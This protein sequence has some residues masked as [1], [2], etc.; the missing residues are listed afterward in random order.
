MKKNEFMKWQNNEI[1][2]GEIIFDITDLEKAWNARGKADVKKL[3]KELKNHL[4][5]HSGC[6][7]ADGME[8][9]ISILNEESK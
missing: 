8:L 1:E 5:A 4:K 2:K 3:E 7:Y 9:A 6:I